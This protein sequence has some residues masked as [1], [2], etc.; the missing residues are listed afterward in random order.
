MNTRRVATIAFAI[1]AGMI[2]LSNY[3]LAHFGLL[4][5]FFGLTIPA[6]TYCAAVTFPARDVVQRSG[7]RIWGI[8]AVLTGAALAYF[9]APS[10]AVASAV[11]YLCSESIDFG[12]Y[13]W[14]QGQYVAAI[15]ASGIFASIVDSWVFLQIAGFYTPSAFQGLVLAKWMVVTVAT[16]IL[17]RSRR[18]I[19]QVEP[20]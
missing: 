3:L 7:G 19:P 13:T 15:F 2:V 18:Y 5:F 14:L 1:Y 11:A 20:T 16:V 12:V 10:L 9:I 4:P 17:W 8:V 6:G